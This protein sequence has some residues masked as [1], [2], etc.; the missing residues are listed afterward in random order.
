MA[1]CSNRRNRLQSIRNDINVRN[2]N[3][4]QRLRSLTSE[5]DTGSPERKP[6]PGNCP[7]CKNY[8]LLVSGC[9]E[10]FVSAWKHLESFMGWIQAWWQFMI[11]TTFCGSA[12]SYGIII[13]LSQH[14][15]HTDFSFHRTLCF[16][17]ASCLIPEMRFYLHT[18]DNG[19]RDQHK[20]SCVGCPSG[21]A[22]RLTQNRRTTLFQGVGNRPFSSGQST[23]I[24]EEA[25]LGL[26][27]GAGCSAQCG[28][29]SWPSSCSLEWGWWG[30]RAGG[31]TSLHGQWSHLLSPLLPR[32]VQAPSL[33]HRL[34][35]ETIAKKGH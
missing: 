28:H 2:E 3:S 25:I 24:F 26:L 17:D 4:R 18:A 12:F 27:V 32:A 22:P 21:R 20:G 13:S 16:N 9:L 15:A 5:G 23:M 6:D 10:R 1:L 30:A 8:F 11:N 7:M 31:W 29:V 35:Q 34:L 19:P 14:P 33:H